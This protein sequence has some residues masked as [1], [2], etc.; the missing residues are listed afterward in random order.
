AGNTAATSTRRLS[1]PY[2]RY[3]AAMVITHWHSVIWN[4]P[5]TRTSSPTCKS[6]SAW[7]TGWRRPNKTPDSR[8]GNNF[9][10]V[11]PSDFFGYGF[12]HQVV[13]DRYR[14]VFN[15]FVDVISDGSG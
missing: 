9:G 6:V 3:A 8:R 1:V 2:R 11:I 7:K 4:C 14:P 10:F 5:T 12:A 15:T 13:I